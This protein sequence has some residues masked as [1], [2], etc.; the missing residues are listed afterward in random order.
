MLDTN[1]DDKPGWIQIICG[2][3]HGDKLEWVQTVCGLFHTVGLT[4]KGEVFTWGSNG[5][6]QLG[7]GDKKTRRVPTKVLGLDGLVITNISCGDYRTAALTDKGEMYTW[8]V[9][10]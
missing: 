7:H 6:G 4:K 3:Y 8:Y 5:S 10:S 2:G 1:T 9:H